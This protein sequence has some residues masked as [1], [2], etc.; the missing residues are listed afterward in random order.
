VVAHLA[1]DGC[2]D[3]AFALHS[4]VQRS[5]SETIGCLSITDQRQQPQS[6]RLSEERLV[7]QHLELLLRIENVLDGPARILHG[8]SNISRL[9]HERDF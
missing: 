7:V 6:R 4:R 5:C 9:A 1:P 3:W 8:K 2:C